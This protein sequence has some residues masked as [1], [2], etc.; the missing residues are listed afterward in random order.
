MTVVLAPID[1]SPRAL[2]A[3]PWAA[4]LAGRDGTVVLLRV[5]PPQPDYAE[6]LFSLVGAED[7]VQDIQHAWTRTAEADL[8]EAAALLSESEVTVEQLVAEGEPD[9]AIA[10]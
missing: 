4:K 7:T 2:R 9:E 3:V 1:G 6:S 10:A 5:V 8:G